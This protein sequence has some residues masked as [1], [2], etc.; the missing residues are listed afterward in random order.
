MVYKAILE[1]S[2]AAY[3]LGKEYLKKRAA[4]EAAK[5]KVSRQAI[6]KAQKSQK[7]K[8]GSEPMTQTQKD[9]LELKKSLA[10]REQRVQTQ[11]Q[12]KAEPSPPKN[13][14]QRKAARDKAQLKKSAAERAYR[15]QQ[16]GITKGGGK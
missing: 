1:G 8:T 11:T 7:P 14:G 10:E 6:L 12:K 9:K 4:A 3:G 2:K 5:N 13:K 15:V 16:M